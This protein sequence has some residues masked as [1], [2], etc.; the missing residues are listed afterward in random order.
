MGYSAIRIPYRETRSFS[1]LVVDYLD[2]HPSLKGF[3]SHESSLR[4][5]Q[6]CIEERRRCATDRALLVK[7]LTAQYE[8]VEMPAKTK[9]QLALL[10]KPTCFTVTTA[11]QNNLFS[12]PL[13][14]TYKILHAIALAND[15][16]K[17]IPDCD[18]VPVFYMGTEDADLA[19]LDHVHIGSEKIQWKTSQT[20]AVGSMKVDAN[21][22][23]LIDRLEGQLGV[24]P[25]GAE[26]VQLLRNSYAEG[27]TLAQATFR[28]VHTLFASY[29]L[30]VLLPDD[31][32][33]KRSFAPILK[34]E[35][36]E[37]FVVPL[38]Q[39]PA[40][41]LAAAGYKVQASP[42]AINLFYLQEGSRERIEKQGDQWLVHGTSLTFSQETLLKELDQ[43][44][45]HFSPNVLLRGLYQCTLLP[46][47]AFIGG[48]A[49]IAYWL[50]VKELFAAANVPMPVLVL[51]NSFLLT[52]S[53]QL[54]RL[55]PLGLSPEQLFTPIDELMQVLV[56]PSM[57]AQRDLGK[58]R[59]VLHQ[60]YQQIQQEAGQLDATLMAHVASLEK[61]AQQGLEA[62]EKKLWRVIKRKHQE[63]QM[64]LQGIKAQW[65]PGDQLQERHQHLGYFYAQWGK[66]LID[67]LLA[68]SQGLTQEFTILN[69]P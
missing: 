57:L 40:R 26:W 12:G 58:E 43:H 23:T 15:L 53:T 29:G 1:S 49:E 27:L 10:S 68:N 33:L 18:F 25:H 9:E 11:H 69:L 66:E 30:L 7:R 62:L 64:Q 16:K 35:L 39:Q 54:K 34:K 8:A 61:R 6:S 45:E 41:A 56:G 47:V 65:F 2:H 51:R 38:V 21:L 4:G 50:Q 20:G 19:E 22:L 59:A 67:Q 63:Q 31:K 44:P 37:Q 36:L 55:G 32:E 48:G 52:E 46:D 28:L 5:I 3:S 17:K 42:R 24:F 60:L 14:F 13:Y